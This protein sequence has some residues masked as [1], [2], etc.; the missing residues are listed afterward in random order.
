MARDPYMSARDDFRE[1][2][3]TKGQIL[4]RTIAIFIAAFAGW[5]ALGVLTYQDGPDDK[6]MIVSLL[7]E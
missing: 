5:F 4:L 7:S 2:I 6:P 3:P 1:R